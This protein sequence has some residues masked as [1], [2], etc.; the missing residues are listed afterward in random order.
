MLLYSTIQRVFCTSLT[1][2]FR[3][4]PCPATF[5]LAFAGRS[6]AFRTRFHASLTL[7]DMLK[8]PRKA[9]MTWIA[10]TIDSL[11][12]SIASVAAVS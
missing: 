1:T 7:K 10:F 6:A 11:M 2:Y 8:D 5:S 9:F 3:T 4:L 12:S